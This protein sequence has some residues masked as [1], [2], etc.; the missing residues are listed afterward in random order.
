M[1]ALQNRRR[2]ASRATICLTLFAVLAAGAISGCLSIGGKTVY[3]NE[4]TKARLDTLESRVQ[5]LEYRAPH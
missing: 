3:E 4:E 2:R 1:S 5:Q